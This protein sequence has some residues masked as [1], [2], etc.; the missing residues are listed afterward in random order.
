MSIPI[1]VSDL[2]KAKQAEIWK[3][4]LSTTC[5]ARCE[6]LQAPINKNRDR[7][8][9]MK[10]RFFV[11]RN[12]ASDTSPCRVHSASDPTVAKEDR[13]P[14]RPADLVRGQPS[15]RSSHHCKNGE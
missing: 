1:R 14:G 2:L 7:R 13:D 10:S 15:L 8:A 5:C 11:G 9:T 4:L 12:R 3:Q 6:Q